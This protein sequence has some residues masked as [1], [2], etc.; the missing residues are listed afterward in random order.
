MTDH[1]EPLPFEQ[2]PDAELGAA[3]RAALDGPAPEAFLARLRR[4]VLQERE[5]SW[6]VLSRWAPYGVAAAAAAA[7]VMWL[8]V[9]PLADP[10][11][12]TLTASA[13]VQM[14]AA[15]HQSESDVLVISL[16]EDR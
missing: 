2:A 5:D 9:R 4:S 8:L 16:M 1:E 3:L 7:A 12:A 10:V 15:P 6:D 11:P 13:P 14:E